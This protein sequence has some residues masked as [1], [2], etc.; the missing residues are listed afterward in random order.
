[1]SNFRI[2][3][4]RGIPA[5]LD[6]RLTV[7][8]GFDKRGRAV[9]GFERITRVHRERARRLRLLDASND[10][11]SGTVARALKRCGWGGRCRSCACPVCARGRRIWR[12]ASVLAFL[13]SYPAAEL[14]FVTLIN[15]ADEIPA[16]ALHT[17]DPK[18]LINRTRRQLE[19]LG[20]PKARVFLIGGVDGE[21]DEGWQV[22]QP[23]IHAI[24]WGVTKPQLRALAAKWPKSR[25]VR[26]PIRI[27]PI[28]DL[29]RVVAYLE[30]SFWGSV[31]R[32]DNPLGIYPHG[33][34]RPPPE[35]E[36]EVLRWLHQQKPRELRLMF[37]VKQYGRVIMK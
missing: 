35:I 33:R 34:R 37:G 31:A 14:V 12:S 26:V 1:M 4:G 32:R 23:H 27:E 2:R 36:A 9:D 25:R 16:G 3:D 17:F 24:A 20:I 7:T 21:W 22:Y 29:P 19:R 28:D 10:R 18:K 11:S 30:K 8:S 6:V 13:A 5:H 15:P